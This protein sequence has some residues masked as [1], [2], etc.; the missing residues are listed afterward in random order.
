MKAYLKELMYYI[1]AGL[2][3]WYCIILITDGVHIKQGIIDSI[4]ACMNI[5]IPSLFAFMAASGI[6]VS[7]G[8]YSFI[9]KPFSLF[10]RFII[11]MPSSLFS[12]FLISNIAGYPVGAKLICDMYDNNNINKKTAQVMQCFC[13]GAGPAFVGSAV[14]LEL[15]GSVKIGMIVF[16]SCVIS[17]LA[18]AAVMCRLF[19]L[20][21][22]QNNT[23]LH[24]DSAI[25]T[26][27]VLS[28]GKSLVSVCTLI[29]FFSTLIT[30]LEHYGIIG[31]ICRRVGLNGSEGLLRSVLDITNLA[32]MHSAAYSLIPVIAGICSLGGICVIIQ[33]KA[34]TASRYSLKLFV[35]TRPIV[36]ALSV[37]NSFWLLKIMLPD[38]LETAACKSDIFVKVNNFVPSVCLILM[39]FLLKIKKRVAFSKRV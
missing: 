7:S 15:F 1:L 21:V 37:V 8:L 18:L 38:S 11:G 36:C 27:S 6:I 12:I 32:R 9:S 26:D 30:T 4:E 29:V 35:L 28:A 19:K 31:S 24:F 17:N 23:N 34:L 14:G 5:I 13:F 22:I 2:I 39:I 25:L 10:S 20:K 16:L 3:V 33:I